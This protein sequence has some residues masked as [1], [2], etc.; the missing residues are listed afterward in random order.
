MADGVGAHNCA[1]RGRFTHPFVSRSQYNIYETAATSPLDVHSSSSS[2]TNHS[3]NHFDQNY[4]DRKLI[5]F[6]ST[7]VEK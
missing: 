7:K 2:E 1:A 4:P 6:F 3:R 5:V